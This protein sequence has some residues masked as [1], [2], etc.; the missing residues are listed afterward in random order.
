M[1]EYMVI[2]VDRPSRMQEPMNKWAK[3]GWEVKSTTYWKNA[4]EDFI[5]ITFE[6]EAID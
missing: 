3:E 2:T 6:R 5:A 1:K 4:T